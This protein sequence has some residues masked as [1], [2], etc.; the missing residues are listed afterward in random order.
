M[1]GPV[2][3][4]PLC[5]PVLS[6]LTALSLQP[7]RGDAAFGTS[8][9]TLVWSDEFGGSALNT[10]IWNREVRPKYSV[11]NE[12]QHYTADVANAYLENGELVIRAIPL[13]N[14]EYSSARLNTAG[15]REATYGYAEVRA[16]VPEF[17][18][19]WPAL[20]FLS[21]SNPY[22]GWPRSGELDLFE[23][24]GCTAGRLF[25][26]IHC[27]AYNGA[28]GTQTGGNVD[29]KTAT[30]SYLTGYHV[31]QME[32]TADKVVFGVDG[33][34]VFTFLNDGASNV[35]TWP[36]NRP[37]MA[38]FNIAVGGDW[39]GFCLNGAKP[40]FPDDGVTNVMRVDYIRWYSQVGAA[41]PTPAPVAAP[42][43]PVAP[44]PGCTA[45]FPS[46]HP[47]CENRI[48]WMLQG[49]PP[50]WQSATYTS[51]G[52]DGTR[53]AIQD[54]L[55]RYENLPL[56]W[57]P[58]VVT[59][60]PVTPSPVATPATLRPSQQPATGAPS[61]PP[62]ADCPGP[63]PAAFPECDN[64]I[65]W[66]LAQDRWNNA[67]YTSKGVVGTRCSVQAYLHTFENPPS[68]YC[69]EVAP[70]SVTDLPTPMPTQPPSQQPPS[71]SGDSAAPGA[72]APAPAP[73]PGSGSSSTGL[74][75]A[76]VAGV[77]VLGALAT[78]LVVRHRAQEGVSDLAA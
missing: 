16:K 20:W 46:T 21:S 59:P 28:A 29:V 71:P 56:G 55:N 43:A 68:G 64:R 73:A 18:G 9:R 75:A 19:S 8:G 24:V 7:Q 44:G 52:V 38:I 31:Y 27:Q 76:S 78:V 48:L 26:T 40:T 12:L 70:A 60:S 47:E 66:M 49:S 5:V 53:C 4:G 57:C 61:A 36:F 30:G 33:T 22:G 39:G 25:Q 45:P 14:G 15:K 23:S 77:V 62:S 34:V 42:V 10:S 63:F 37:F 65:A 72:G 67:I 6:V 11:N 50:N 35:D 74:V 54:Y 17:Q 51:K 1:R 3:R 58:P 13:G 2:W 41:T 32:W 69:P